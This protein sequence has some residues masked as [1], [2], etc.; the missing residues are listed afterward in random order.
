MGFCLQYT[1][2]SLVLLTTPVGF[3]GFTPLVSVGRVYLWSYLAV[4]VFLL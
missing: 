1:S 2:K 3:A 4:E